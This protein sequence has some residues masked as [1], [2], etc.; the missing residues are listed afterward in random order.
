MTLTSGYE[1]IK[2]G[3]HSGNEAGKVNNSE[4][5]YEFYKVDKG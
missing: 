2:L 3:S 4:C 1:G 5:M